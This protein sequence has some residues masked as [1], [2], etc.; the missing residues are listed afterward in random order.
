M[1]PDVIDQ[2]GNIVNPCLDRLEAYYLETMA[3]LIH[4]HHQHA[5]ETDAYE[6]PADS[7][8]WLAGVDDSH[9]RKQTP[10]GKK[11]K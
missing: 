6:Q 10:K 3:A 5:P 4:Q 9:A 7:L 11:V 8:N 2:H 1:T